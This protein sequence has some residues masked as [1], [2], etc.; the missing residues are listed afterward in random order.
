MA[1]ARRGLEMPDGGVLLARPQ[2]FERRSLERVRSFLHSEAHRFAPHAPEPAKLPA[3]DMRPPGREPPEAAGVVVVAVASAL[4]GGLM[5][6]LLAGQ[7]RLA[8][9][10]AAALAVGGALGWVARGLMAR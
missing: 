4:S 5:G 8:F 3:P 10:V 6:F 2:G 7:V 9:A 1:R